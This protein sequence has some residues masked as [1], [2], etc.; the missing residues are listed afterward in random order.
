MALNEKRPACSCPERDIPID[1]SD[2]GLRRAW[3]I[4]KYKY[5]NSAM[6]GGARQNIASKAST[7]TCEKCGAVWRS[8]AGYVDEIA[9]RDNVPEPHIGLIDGDGNPTTQEEIDRIEEAAKA[10]KE[11]EKADRKAAREKEA[12]EKRAAKAKEVAEKKAA[13]AA[14]DAANPANQPAAS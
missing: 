10:E 3:K 5:S 1:D 6:L 7:L 12:E 2:N 9:A 14:A 4:L 8:S 11:K 13:K